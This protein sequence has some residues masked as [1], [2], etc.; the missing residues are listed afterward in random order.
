MESVQNAILQGHPVDWFFLV[1]FSFSFL[2]LVIYL[3]VFVL[4]VALHKNLPEGEPNQ[5]SLL[6]TFRNEE[7]NLR[8]NLESVLNHNQVEY[9]VVA[10]DNC[11]HDDSSSILTGL[12][13]RYTSLVTSSLK[14]DVLFSEKMVQ[15][16][17]L[18]AARY[19]WVLVIS[20]SVNFLESNWVQ[21]VT[22]N[23]NSEKNI[24]ANY[25]NVKPERS[26]FNLLYRV[27]LFFQQ[28]KAFGF[29]KNGMPFVSAQENVAFRKQLYF[30]EGGYRGKMSEPFAN[31]ELVINSF[32]RK[33]PVSLV[34]SH[35]TT[36]YRQEL[37]TWKEY[38]ELLKKEEN[39]KK[40]LPAGTRFLLGVFEWAYLLLIP[41]GA[42]VAFRIPEIWPFVTGLIIC[43]MLCGLLIIKKMHSRL[44]EFK[45][46]LPSFL[47]A[48][49]L[50]Y[51]K[52]VFRIRYFRYGQNKEWKIGN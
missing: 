24:V 26:F 37:I 15:N 10:V 52:L 13:G 21:K 23:L 46:F 6:L 38:L 33:V 28:V 47:I 7:D 45:L 11:S 2:I 43:L 3:L 49:I 40:N 39:I 5:L 34:L 12:K 9:E 44:Q 25:S 18:K 36:F 19:E 50:P 20:P 42:V 4:R 51:V 31:L 1:I 8:S 35:E 41:F 22:A 48:L 14:Q 30:N 29:I 16:I 32:I 27:E 17:A